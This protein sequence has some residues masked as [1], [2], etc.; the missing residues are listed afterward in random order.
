MLFG[1][2]RRSL[3]VSVKIDFLRRCLR[4][5]LPET[6]E[7]LE[8]DTSGIC[9][10]CRSS[11]V[12][13]SM[14]DWDERKEI[15]GKIIDKHRG[16]N[17]YDCIIPFSGGKDST[18]T[19]YYLMKEF[20][21]K[22]LVVRFN[23]GFYRQ[24]TIENT[25]RTLK[26]LGADFL[27]FT[28]NWHIVKFLMRE[29]FERKT[30]FCWHCH[31]GIY[32][33]PLRVALMYQV[34]LIFWGEP[35]SEITNYYN[36]LDDEIEYEDWSKFNK[37]RNL[38]ISSMDMYE[39]LIS[40]GIDVEERE[41]IPYTFPD[42]NL[43]KK[44]GYISVPLGSFI[45]WNYHE[46]SK[47]IQDQLGWENDDLENVPQTLNTHGEK[48]ECFM[49]GTRDY[50]KYLK[51]GY[52]RA[53]QISAFKARAGEMS[54]EEAIANSNG[55]DGQIPYSLQIFLEYTGLTIDEF[56]GFVGDSIVSP[57]NKQAWK[58]EASKELSD[59]AQWYRE[60]NS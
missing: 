22:P 43:L 15:L 10:I 9:N 20:K 28:P 51:R 31:C 8:F 54:A 59:S 52:G 41:L 29:S 37:I 5:G 23:H 11:D 48:I 3:M 6:Y 27:E 45:P 50:I 47:V 25:D 12:K 35:Q 60:D 26:K 34:P 44:M 24:N 36:Y 39:M 57:W 32:T 17:Q 16:K 58:N 49:Q 13:L 46:N 53:M 4:C 18:F 2:I 30:D 55:N 7:T 38:G 21:V 14:I 33:Y 42:E 1:W 19:L 40:R 56:Y